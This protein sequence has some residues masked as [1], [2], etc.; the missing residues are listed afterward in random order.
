MKRFPMLLSLPSVKNEKGAVSLIQVRLLGTAILRARFQRKQ[1]SDRDGHPLQIIH[2]A[3]ICVRFMVPP[4]LI[5][6]L[7]G[8]LV[9]L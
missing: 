9:G 2:M 8:R 7:S 5:S 6:H 3:I 1:G 4:P